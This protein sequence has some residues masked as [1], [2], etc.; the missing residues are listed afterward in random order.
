MATWLEDNWLRKLN[1]KFE[2]V[3]RSG[4]RRLD[5]ALYKHSYECEMD[6]E[7]APSPAIPLRPDNTSMFTKLWKDYFGLHVE[8]PT[9]SDFGNPSDAIDAPFENFKNALK[10]FHEQIS[11]R[12]YLQPDQKTP[13]EGREED[14]RKLESAT[15]QFY[16]ET[17]IYAVEMYKELAL[18]CIEP[19]REQVLKKIHA[20]PDFY[21]SKLNLV[22]PRDSEYYMSY[23]SSYVKNKLKELYDLCDS[24]ADETI[25]MLSRDQYK[26]N[27]LG[28][29]HTTFEV[30]PSGRDRYI[31]NIN[32]KSD[33]YKTRKGGFG[34]DSY[35]IFLNKPASYD[36]NGLALLKK[37]Y[38]CNSFLLQMPALE[39]GKSDSTETEVDLCKP[40]YAQ[41][42][43]Q[44]GTYKRAVDKG[45]FSPVSEALYNSVLLPTLVSKVPA[46]DGFPS[47][48]TYRVANITSDA[49]AKKLGGML[50][51]DKDNQLV[52]RLKTGETLG[53]EEAQK[54]WNRLYK[55]DIMY[56]IDHP[57]RTYSDGTPVKLA[58]PIQVK[59]LGGN[60][61]VLTGHLEASR[62]LLRFLKNS[63]P[64]GDAAF[65]ES[66]VRLL[67]Y[68]GYIIAVDNW[69]RR[70]FLSNKPS[71]EK[72]SDFKKSKDRYKD[73]NASIKLG[74]CKMKLRIPDIDIVAQEDKEMQELGEENQ[75]TPEIRLQVE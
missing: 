18:K 33:L 69:D 56:A 46:S 57:S 35:K 63:F 16:M 65:I 59:K 6:S 26:T 25:R 50:D 39:G 48:E 51:I 58:V 45:Y 19:T 13:I 62:R 24:L 31:V 72:I 60:S 43:F 36:K 4:R 54:R 41:R 68:G 44:N 5:E 2:I 21:I 28:F 52:L 14:N 20:S 61:N 23:F 38:G 15:R 10:G 11:M 75:I 66:L 70:Y 64:T 47:L 49:F 32:A 3:V 34:K 9:D 42:F 67:V 40:E 71:F 30:R 1:E 74:S 53:V 27:T 29:A 7:E 55:A 17:M 8:V 37:T 73:Y 22:D 12:G